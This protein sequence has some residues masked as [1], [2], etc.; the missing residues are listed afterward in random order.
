M[1]LSTRCVFS[2]RHRW[3]VGLTRRAHGIA[4]ALIVS[5]HVLIGAAYALTM[6]LW[7]THEADFL[8]VTRILDQRGRLADETDYPPG[9]A[10]MR[11]ATHPPLYT[12]VSLPVVALMD[13]GA[14]APPQALPFLICPGGETQYRAVMEYIP[15]PAYQFP[16]RGAP[17]AGYGLRLLNVALSASAVILI[18]LAARAA[19]PS[20]PSVALLAAALL[21]FEPYTLRLNATINND[22]LLIAVSA[23]NILFAARLLHKLTVFDLIGLIV[24]TGLALLTKVNGW[25]FFGFN[26]LILLWL[27][28]RERRRPAARGLLIGLVIIALVGVVVGVYNSLTF[29]SVFGRYQQ[30]NAFALDVLSNLAIPRA[31]LEGVFDATR[32][33]YLEPLEALSPRNAIRVGYQL[34]PII[35]GVSLCAALIVL[36]RRRE[37]SSASV[38]LALFVLIVLT[39]FIVVYRNRLDADASNTSAYNTAFVYAPLRY[40]AT[41]L[42]ALALS[43]AAGLGIVQA[44]MKI[45]AL[46]LSMAALWLFVA[47]AGVIILVFNRPVV[48]TLT[49]RQ[50]ES[51]SKI[52]RVHISQAASPYFMGY[53]IGYVAPGFVDVTLYATTTTALDENYAV[54]AALT[55]TDGNESP[56]EFLPARGAYPTALWQAYD[57]VRIE[58]RIPN[59]LASPPVSLMLDWFTTQPN[60]LTPADT[61]PLTFPISQPIARADTCPTNLGVIDGAYQI[62]RFNSPDA[63][64]RGAAYLPSLNWIVYEPSPHAALRIFSFTHEASG[65]VY[66]CAGSPSDVFRTLPMWRRGEYLYFDQCAMRFPP[67]APSGAYTVAVGIQNTNGAYLEP[68]QIPVGTVTLEGE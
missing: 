42:P 27:V 22:T 59:C 48:T 1:G 25:L 37:R 19:F 29:G 43:M 61:A 65:A 18:F 68:G 26:G 57:I 50:F 20:R 11:Q 54:R 32:L 46:S 34:M 62:V 33:S 21:A 49:E 28:W 63:I 10:A 47:A 13:D 41:M 51:L 39:C 35:G 67:E 14:E 36:V 40:Y 45:H 15:T 8:H 64:A 16:P 2:S 55:D 9:E 12:L 23:A 5:V 3:S 66:T 44:R 52:Q 56:C 58:A 53:Q 30:L 4:L 7:R 38:L 6:P 60:G 31:V 17:A 24:V